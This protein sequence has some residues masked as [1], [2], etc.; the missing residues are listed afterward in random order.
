[1]AHNLMP[2][3]ISVFYGLVD[4]IVLNSFKVVPTC[5]YYLTK[6]VMKI[7]FLGSPCN[8]LVHRLDE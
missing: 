4:V 8:S 6:Q 1:M 5:L 7:I 3:E 2:N